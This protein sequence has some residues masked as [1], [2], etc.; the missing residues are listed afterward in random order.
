MRQ[1]AP[2]RF[3]WVVLRPTRAHLLVGELLIAYGLFLAWNAPD[4]LD[5]TIGL[6]LF[7]HM[8]AASMGYSERATRGHFDSILAGRSSRWPI[9]RVH[10]A[11]SAAPGFALWALLAGI[12]LVARPRHWPPS[13]SISGL[14]AFVWV[15]A[16]AW[17]VTLRLV[18]HAGGVLW[19]ALLFA[20]A[21][22]RQM[23]PLQQMFMAGDATWT[24]ALP[25]AGA[26]LV[27]PAF[28]VSRP[29]VAGARTLI[30]VFGS[31]FVAWTIGAWLIVR[32]DGIL[33]DTA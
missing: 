19:L 2:W 31:A 26:I 15:S 23:H 13:V 21:A 20:L 9:A 6:A 12:D 30:L 10:W 28:L 18:R 29:Q 24:E 11:L 5:Q 3:F 7:L 27:F 4:E 8:F 33:K 14:A 32:F 25:K 16:A 17:T 1:P 22:A